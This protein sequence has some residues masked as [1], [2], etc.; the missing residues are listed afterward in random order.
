MLRRHNSGEL[1]ARYGAAGDG[2]GVGARSSVRAVAT[3]LALVTVAEV[4][5]YAPAYA[6]GNATMWATVLAMTL[7]VVCGVALVAAPVAA[8]ARRHGG[9][10]AA[11]VPAALAAAV[12]GAGAAG[13]AGGPQPWLAAAGLATLLVALGVWA[14]RRGRLGRSATAPFAALV[15]GAVLWSAA[16]WALVEAGSWKSARVFV[17]VA[18]AAYLGVVVLAF[19]AGRG[20]VRPLAA[21]AFLGLVAFRF[22][23]PHPAD[24]VVT[25]VPE[26]RDG[27]P[28]ILVILDT[29]RADVLDLDPVRM[30]A[31]ARWAEAADV[32]THAVANASWTLP[33]HASIMTGRTVSEHRTDATRRPGFRTAIP[34]EL[35]TL[36]EALARRGYRTSC[37][38][39]N[40]IVGPATALSRG[41]QE[42][43]NPGFYWLASTYP[44]RWARRLARRSE[45]DPSQVVATLFGRPSHADAREITSRALTHLDPGGPAPA[46]FLF[47]NYMDAHRP[48]A[49]PPGAAW[50]ARIGYALDQLRLLYGDLDFAEFRD[51]RRATIRADYRGQVQRLDLEVGR[52]LAAYEDRGWLD[53][54][55]VL[56]TA[57]HGQALWENPSN[58]GYF[59]HQGG[60]EPVVRIPLLVKRPGQVTGSRRSELAQQSDL[61]DWVL[62]QIDGDGRRG[63]AAGETAITEWYPRA[64][65]TV[66]PPVGARVGIYAGRYKLVR[67]ADGRELLFD[68]E[69][70]PFET[71]DL[72]ASRP[73]LVADLGRRLD[74]RWAPPAAGDSDTPIDDALRARLGALG[75]LR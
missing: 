18:I 48:Y 40:G 10:T 66:T 19:V 20:R 14:E 37:V 3:V 26:R 67:E 43:E 42:Y 39:A 28:V 70:S 63:V 47:V 27:T 53:E 11:V 13:P 6:L 23:V 31:L 55:L 46:H 51:R 68:V 64:A 36:P 30:P 69:R 56:V 73:D 75:Y 60:F 17:A 49:A 1:V 7:A 62:A 65:E 52:L 21:A 38:T 32:Y 2:A 71:E 74:A 50:G 12:A 25:D 5:A 29:L 72:A 9:S 33:A 41:C 57:D 45:W 24:P 61:L 35:E 44:M 59:G 15:V 4:L 8:L 22:A 58:P 34:A 54:A 16:R